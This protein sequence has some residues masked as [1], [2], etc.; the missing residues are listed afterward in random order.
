MSVVDVVEYIDS[1]VNQQPTFPCPDAHLERKESVSR[2]RIQRYDNDH[3]HGN[4]YPNP[5]CLYV[6]MNQSICLIGEMEERFRQAGA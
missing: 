4:P 3:W 2:N 5:G 6:P 1:G